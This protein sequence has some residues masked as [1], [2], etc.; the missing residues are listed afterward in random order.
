MNE[1]VRS[2]WPELEWI[3]SGGRREKTARIWEYALEQS[4]LRAEPLHG[5]PFNDE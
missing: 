5:I 1:A 3:E 2:L 4:A